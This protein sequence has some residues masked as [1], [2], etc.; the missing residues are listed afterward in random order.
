MNAGTNTDPVPR[1]VPLLRPIG[2][3]LVALVTWALVAVLLAIP[4]MSVDERFFGDTFAA[5]DHAGPCLTA[6]ILGG[7]GAGALV[8]GFLLRRKDLT[9]AALWGGLRRLLGGKRASPSEERDQER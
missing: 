6:A 2:G 8:Y 7:M 9:G 4:A 3:C 5:T 1:G